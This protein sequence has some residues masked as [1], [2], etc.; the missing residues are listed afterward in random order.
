MFNT[1]RQIGAAI[2]VATFGPLLGTAHNLRDGF[3]TCVTV[4][5]AATAVAFALTLLA[6]LAADAAPAPGPHAQ[7]PCATSPP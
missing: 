3:A 6:R 7:A 4:G 5:A 1:S 2:G